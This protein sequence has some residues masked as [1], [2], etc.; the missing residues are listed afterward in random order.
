MANRYDVLFEMLHTSLKEV[1]KLQEDMLQALINS[2]I[3][4]IFYNISNS[5]WIQNKEIDRILL[6]NHIR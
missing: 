6:Y 3:L 1:L 4:K 2:N 5:F